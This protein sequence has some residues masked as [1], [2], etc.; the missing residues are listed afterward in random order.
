[1]LNIK[2]EMK[3]LS[4]WPGLSLENYYFS[5]T[6]KITCVLFQIV[7]LKFAFHIRI[8]FVYLKPVKY[9]LSVNY[10]DR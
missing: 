8:L 2:R 10:V 1:M 6:K 5:F 4:F 3:V 9:D 7:L